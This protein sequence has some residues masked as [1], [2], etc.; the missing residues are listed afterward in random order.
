M[1]L[2]SLFLPIAFTLSTCAYARTWTS[3]DGRTIEASL[4]SSSEN[5]VVLR[6]DASGA[7][8]TVTKSKLSATDL[9]FVEK[10]TVSD[11]DIILIIGRYPALTTA[12]DASKQLNEKY[13]G[14]VK[15]MTPATAFN[16][17]QLMRKKLSDDIKYWKA[18]SERP[19]PP[20]PI[21]AISASRAQRKTY[22]ENRAK[23]KEQKKIDKENY[24]WV[25]ETLPA[26]IAEV[27]KAASQQ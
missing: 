13:A 7:T 19:I 21:I 17:C 2:K 8:V 23:D 6:L 11:K 26:W 10:T 3:T 12:G 25:S 22:D 5:S 1:L 24:K 9:A 16:T 15:I 20:P 14:F 4:V 27:E 18:E